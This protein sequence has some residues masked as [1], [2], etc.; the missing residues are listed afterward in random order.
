M[1]RVPAPAPQRCSPSAAAV[2]SFSSSTGRSYSRSA[3][4][5]TGTSRQPGRCGGASTMPR[6][7][8]SGPPQPTPTAS[9]SSHSIPERS[10]ASR[11]S[12][13]R[14]AST[15][16]TPRSVRLGR[17]TNECT[18]PLSS[19]TP[20]ASF[21]PP[22]SSPRTGVRPPAANDLALAALQRDPAHEVALAERED[23][24]HRE[25]REHERGHDQLVVAVASRRG[26]VDAEQDVQAERHGVRV[27]AVQVDERRHQVHPLRLELEQERH[28]QR[29]LRER[30]RDPPEH[31]QVVVAVHPR[32]LEVLARDAEEELP[33]QED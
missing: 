19:T 8:S 26:R 15:A 10:T 9:I 1:L 22:M 30:E 21:V 7:A 6:S 13:N 24:Q 3:S 18:P 4:A 14:S 31:R 12:A 33:L 5:F 23:E 20:A 25:R 2:A 16:S 29:R 28:D 27:V 32:R 17:T 11:P